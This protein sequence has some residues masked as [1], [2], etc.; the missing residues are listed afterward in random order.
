MP[1]LG[2]AAGSCIEQNMPVP[3][4]SGNNK[5]ELCACDS[6]QCN[7]APFSSQ[8]T[9]FGVLLPAIIAIAFRF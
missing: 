4:T 3:G 1:G 8:A 7:S 5:V 9:L 6:D 2:G